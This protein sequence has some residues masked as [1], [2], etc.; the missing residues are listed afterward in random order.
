M[1]RTTSDHQTAAGMTRFVRVIVGCLLLAGAIVPAAEP[2]RA[3]ACQPTTVTA[4][5]VADAWLD[6]SSPAA[7]KGSDSVLS[8]DAGALDLETGVPSGRA[9]ALVRLAM[10]AAVPD[11]CVVASARLSL[12][13][14]EETPGTRV[15]AVRIAGAWSESSVTWSTQPSTVGTAS[16]T[17]SREGFMHWNVTAQVQAMF[18]GTN[19]GLLIRDAAEGAEAGGGGH[20]FFSREKGDGDTQPAL[21]ISF[22]APG[23]VVDPGRPRPRR[24]PR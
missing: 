16:R 6:E 5:I 3:A 21:T 7:P 18:D 12:F 17:W 10:P 2:T 4:P 13:S 11:G 23:S 14:S 19:R 24:R 1:A 9:R 20:S 22:A 15:D 8:V